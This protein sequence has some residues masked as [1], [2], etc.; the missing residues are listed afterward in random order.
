[1]EKCVPLHLKSKKHQRLPETEQILKNEHI[2]CDSRCPNSKYTNT[3]SIKVEIN[4]NKGVLITV[5]KNCTI[6]RCVH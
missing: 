2:E 1:M 6:K 4:I 3:V 5:H